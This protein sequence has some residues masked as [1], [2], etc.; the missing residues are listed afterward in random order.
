L[1]L[2]ERARAQLGDDFDI[3]DFHDAVLGGGGLPLAILER[4]IDNY[5][6]MS[7]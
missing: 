1:E 6:E 7:R 4:R 5:I 3:R 2:R